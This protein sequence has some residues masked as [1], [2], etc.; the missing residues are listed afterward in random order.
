M[1]YVYMYMYMYTGILKPGI[2]TRHG[3]LLHTIDLPVMELSYYAQDVFRERELE[4]D[5]VLFTAYSMCGRGLKRG[6]NRVHRGAKANFTQGGA[7]PGGMSISGER[8]FNREEVTIEM[9]VFLLTDVVLDLSLSSSMWHTSDADL[10]QSH[11]DHQWPHSHCSYH[12]HSTLRYLPSRLQL[13]LKIAQ[14]WNLSMVIS[15]YDRDSFFQLRLSSG[16]IILI[17]FRLVVLFYRAAQLILLYLSL[18]ASLLV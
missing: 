15:S 12:L 16:Y 14:G 9:R 18:Q 13:G 8:M 17:T 2:E 5:Q 3:Q 10:L 4:G 1:L 6:E 11:L 7:I